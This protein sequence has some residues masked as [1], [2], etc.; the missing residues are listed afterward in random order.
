MPCPY[1][2]LSR[3]QVGAFSR[4]AGGFGKFVAA[5][6]EPLE[7]IALPNLEGSILNGLAHEFGYRGFVRTDNCGNRTLNRVAEGVNISRDG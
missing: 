6:E 2:F 4:I 7:V 3:C 5:A 1:G